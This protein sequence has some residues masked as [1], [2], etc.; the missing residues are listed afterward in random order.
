MMKK[1]ILLMLILA[2][3]LAKTG[4]QAATITVGPGSGYDSETIQAGIDAANNG[5]TV[6]VASGQY[7]ITE[8]IT[9]RGKPITM[10]SEAGADETTIRMGTPNDSKRASVVVFENNET[11]TSVLQGFTIT[12]GRGCFYTDP[13]PGYSGMHGGGIVC[14]TASPTITDCIITQNT[15]YNCGG[16]SVGLGSFPTV[17]NCIISNNTIVGAGAGINCWG[18][19][20]ATMTNCIIRGNSTTGTSLGYNGG[21]GGVLCGIDSD[22]TMNNCTVSENSAGVAGGG[23]L[24]WE[25]G[26]LTMNHCMITD[27]TAARDGGIGSHGSWMALTHCIIA[28]NT[29]QMYNGG[30]K[31]ASD[32]FM[33]ITNCTIFDNSAGQ[34]AGGVYIP[35][36][37]SA[38][39]TNSILRN[40]TAP[41]GPEI[42]MDSLSSKL[43]V[44][45]SN[46]AGGE[47][48]VYQGGSSTI[49]WGAGNL[50]AAPH[51]SDPGNGDYHLK[52]QTGRW[53]PI[54][55]IWIQD[56]V[57]S[58]CIDAG[59]PMSPIGPEAFPNGGFVNMGAYGSTPEA[60]KSYFGEP[61]CETIIAGDING[62]CKVDWADLEIM[63]LHWTDDEPLSLP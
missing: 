6:L 3:A 17:I 47:A 26:T 32:S 7:V 10:K 1:I 36:R 31:S 9:F 60:S 27:N 24:C 43:N 16:L 52:S 46:V 61:I 57:T 55:Q 59:D 33:S 51:F 37:S 25:N 38:T 50:D 44:T 20:S 5:D 28:R 39:I 48:G 56:D 62:D 4:L 2:L 15:A 18:N 12:G 35:D 54:S 21:G 41:L 49:D 11:A 53:D 63:A 23:I 40:N 42:Y 29:A 45:F 34:Y 30:I 19:S 8:P 13:R 58:P 22:L 14:T